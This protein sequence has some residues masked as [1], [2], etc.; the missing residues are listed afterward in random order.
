MRV[1]LSEA[2]GWILKL[3]LVQSASQSFPKG[4][5]RLY[6]WRRAVRFAEWTV[7]RFSS[8]RSKSS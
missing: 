1:V 5:V 4:A 3:G 8:V 7:S 2:I 6:A